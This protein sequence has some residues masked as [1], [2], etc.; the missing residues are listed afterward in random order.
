MKVFPDCFAP[1]MRKAYQ[2]AHLPD[3]RFSGPTGDRKPRPAWSRHLFI[4]VE[5]VGMSFNVVIRG[6]DKRVVGFSDRPNLCALRWNRADGS[7]VPFVI[8]TSTDRA[9]LQAL[10]DGVIDFYLNPAGRDRHADNPLLPVLLEV[11]PADCFIGTAPIRRIGS[12]ST[13]DRAAALAA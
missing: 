12:Y 5:Q 10:V 1:I 2:P 13:F 7:A 9:E 4:D 3:G 6:R 11:F 8:A